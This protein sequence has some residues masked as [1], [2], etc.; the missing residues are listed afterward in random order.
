M[1]TSF[2][3][4]SVNVVEDIYISLLPNYAVRMTGRSGQREGQ[5]EIIK[6][7]QRKKEKKMFR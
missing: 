5:S 6:R 2:S 3:V 1:D 7:V 4:K